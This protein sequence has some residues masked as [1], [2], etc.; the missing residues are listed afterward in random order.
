MIRRSFD[1][2][3]D[4]AINRFVSESAATI[5][6]VATRLRL[7]KGEWFLNL[8]SGVPWYQRVFIK[9]ARL[10]EVDKIIRNKI[11]Q[12]EGVDQLTSFDLRFDRDTR[13]LSVSFSATTIYG[14]EFEDI[15]GLNPLGA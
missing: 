5:Q 4:Y 6:A 3:G 7:F 9:P 11:T 1:E 2:N 10:N 12:T 14:D 13:K 8:E 15:I